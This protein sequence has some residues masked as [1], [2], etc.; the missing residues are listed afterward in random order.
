MGMSGSRR[1]KCCPRDFINNYKLRIFDS[2]VSARPGSTPHSNR[3]K[4][5]KEGQGAEHWQGQ[6]GVVNVAA[7]DEKVFYYPL[8]PHRNRGAEGNS[9]PKGRGPQEKKTAE[10]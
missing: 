1:A 7:W 4:N 8:A 6:D 10:R 5:D 3:R 2:R 9:P